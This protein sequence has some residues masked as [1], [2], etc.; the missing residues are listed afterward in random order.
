[1]SPPANEF[2][3]DL[4]NSSR[5]TSTSTFATPVFSEMA[6]TKSAFLILFNWFRMSYEKNQWFLETRSQISTFFSFTETKL[7][8]ISAFFPLIIK[9]LCVLVICK[10]WPSLTG[11]V[12][13]PCSTHNS[14]CV[15]VCCKGYFPKLWH[16]SRF[17]QPCITIFADCL[18]L[19]SKLWLVFFL[20]N[21][22]TVCCFQ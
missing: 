11:R 18:P 3:T 19:H 8:L 7:N 1:M 4:K 14:R 21:T 16:C 13:P 20:T 17:I 2:F 5:V 22:T 6:V 10:Y 9:G 12:F 15:L